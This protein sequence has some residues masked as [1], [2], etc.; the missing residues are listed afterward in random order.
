MFCERVRI[1]GRIRVRIVPCNTSASNLRRPTLPDER[2]RATSPTTQTNTGKYFAPRTRHDPDEYKRAS[3]D[4]RPTAANALT[5]F[6]L[7][8]ESIESS[9]HRICTF[10]HSYSLPVV[11]TMYEMCERS[12]CEREMC[13]SAQS[14]RKRVKQYKVK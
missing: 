6:A 4:M 1:G 3:D 14:A 7:R 2:C 8:R 10:T 5:R 13:V 12:V 11:I 9:S